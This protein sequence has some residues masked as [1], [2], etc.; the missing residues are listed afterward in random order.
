MSMH[1]DEFQGRLIVSEETIAQ[2]ASMAVKRVDG[3]LAIVTSASDEFQ[4]MIGS[5]KVRGIKTEVGEKE[6]IIDLNLCVAFDINVVE[7]AEKVRGAVARDVSVMT[8]IDVIEI[9]INIVDI[10]EVNDDLEETEV[11]GTTECFDEV[12]DEVIDDSYKTIPG[13][14]TFSEYVSAAVAGR[15]ALQ[16][17]GVAGMNKGIAGELAGFFSDKAFAQGVKVEMGRKEIIID[18]YVDVNFGERIPDISWAIQEKVKS[19]VEQFT[20]LSV[21]EVNI[22]VQGIYFEEDEEA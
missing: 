17:D 22:S 8:G 14:L 18:L 19:A 2:I 7:V 20:G 10:K 4:T 3:V 15:A 5:E 21:K 6:A 12:I 13:A 1:D 11:G 9:N 16:V